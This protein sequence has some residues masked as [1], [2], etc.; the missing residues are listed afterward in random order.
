VPLDR[1]L[2]DRTVSRLHE[3]EAAFDWVGVYLVQDGG[4]VLGPFRGEPTEHVRIPLGAGVCGSV[5]ERGETEV[6]PDVRARPGHIACDIRTRSETVAPI[7][8]VGRVV[9][10]LDVDSN[11]PDAFGPREVGVIE[12]AA[13]EIAAA[14]DARAS[15]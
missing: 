11:T 13:R 3:T 8:I 9:G 1:D 4:L 10:V 15:A 5:A 2:I 6:V 14:T 12:D 7:V